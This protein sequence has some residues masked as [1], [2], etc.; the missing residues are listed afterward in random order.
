MGFSEPQKLHD[1]L[2]WWTNPELCVKTSSL[3]IRQ[4]LHHSNTMVNGQSP[5]KTRKK[6]TNTAYSG[7]DAGQANIALDAENNTQNVPDPPVA[8][9]HHIH[10]LPSSLPN[11]PPSQL[12]GPTV[13]F[14]TGN[15]HETDLEEYAGA[16]PSHLVDLSS[17]KG[18][19]QI[20]MFQPYRLLSKNDP[21]ILARRNLALEL[22]AIVLAKPFLLDSVV[23]SR[24]L[25]NTFHNELSL[26]DIVLASVELAPLAGKGGPVYRLQKEPFWTLWKMLDDLRKRAQSGFELFEPPMPKMP[27]WGSDGLLAYY[28]AN[29]FEISGVCYCA[30]VENYL[31]T[32]DQYF[33]FSTNEARPPTE[34][35]REFYNQYC[36]SISPRIKTENSSPAHLPGFQFYSGTP[37]SSPKLSITRDKSVNFRKVQPT[38]APEDQTEGSDD[39]EVEDVFFRPTKAARDAFG[40]SAT[41]SLKLH[42]TFRPIK[43]KQDH[44]SHQQSKHL[45]QQF[46]GFG[47]R[48]PNGSPTPP[49]NRSSRRSESRI[50]G[51]S[52]VPS[53]PGS[54][55][56]PSSSDD[57]SDRN[58]RKGSKKPS[59][60]PKDPPKASKQFHRRPNGDGD[61]LSSSDGDHG[62]GRRCGLS[63]GGR[64]QARKSRESANSEASDDGRYFDLHLKESDIPKWDGDPDTLLRWIQRCNLI[65]EDG[66]RAR[67]QLSQIV[68]RVFTGTAQDWYFSLPL[69]YQRK[70]RQNWD[71]MKQALADFFLSSKWLDKTRT[72][73]LQASYRQSGHTREKPSEYFIRKRELLSSV[74]SF[75]DTA[76][77]SEVMN[78]AP[79]SWCTVLD[80][81]KYDNIVDFHGAIVFHE[82]TLMDLAVT[83]EDSKLNH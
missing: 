46:S 60:N 11:S 15:I 66:P 73:A 1:L 43:F 26:L 33:N 58:P 77:I 56:D 52:A 7:M 71:S 59:G 68:P 48:I 61:D 72:R 3:P 21:T 64:K 38:L 22:G 44:K 50:A 75:E 35:I 25:F 65:A 4:S 67:N 74:Y 12:R 19:V 29:E 8:T 9:D 34:E 5:S 27:T 32:L 16:Q 76:I 20:L 57:E 37:P 6:E 79:G 54:D 18:I 13:Q 14:H 53:E 70:I 24:R 62:G 2:H 45:P 30:E 82:D 49:A 39:S 10:S 69:D 42:D 83:K 51:R 63:Q 55:G 41:P 17:S 47:F 36:R 80:T 23:A 31:A 28:L 40:K 81:Q 78:G